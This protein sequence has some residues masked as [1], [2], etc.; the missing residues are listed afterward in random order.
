[1]E[2]TA[3]IDTSRF[4]E[5]GPEYLRKQMELEGEAKGGLSAVER[6]AA[7]KPK[8]VKTQRVINSKQ[9]PVITFS[10]ASVSSN[11]SSNRSSRRSMD[12]KNGKGTAQQNIDEQG[13]Q[14]PDGANVVRRSSS[15][16]Q[17]PDS[18]LMY[19]QKCELVKASN[20]KAKESFIRRALLNSLKDKPTVPEATVK[21]CGA[22]ETEP[23]AIKTM[24]SNT[25]AQQTLSVDVRKLRH[26]RVSEIE[27]KSR[28]GVARSH[29]D[30]S[31]RYSKNFSEFD[32]FFK[33]CG[34][35]G[36]VIESLG[37]ENFSARSDDLSLKI[38]SVSVSAS[39]DGFTRESG[40]SDGLLEEEL[41]ENIRQG[42]SVIERNAR[43]IKWL[44]SCKNAQESGKA[45]RD[46]D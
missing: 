8:Y 2:P 13:E 35:D 37:K 31:S 39:D 34:L 43:I 1:M 11:G 27:G 40:D 30:I 26:D 10:S 20:E 42:T 16:R 21:T 3:D 7:T 28:K 24:T 15:K 22:E 44:Y 36:D 29:S 5:K 9:I 25:R 32:I 18:L 45:L 14:S 6:L 41:H 33:Y 38:R 23:G 4:L 46:L 19:R 12:I 17:R